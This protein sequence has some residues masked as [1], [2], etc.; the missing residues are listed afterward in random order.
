MTISPSALIDSFAATAG[1]LSDIGILIEL[2]QGRVV[3]VNPCFTASLGHEGAAVL[4]RT[5][6]EARWVKDG[7]AFAAFV[8]KVAAGGS[9]NASIQQMLHRDGHVVE[10]SL[11]GGVLHAD[12]QRF[13]QLVARDVT[14]IEQLRLEREAIFNGVPVGLALTRARHFVHAN[15]SFE[16]LFGFDPGTLAGQSGRVVWPSDEVYQEFGRRVGPDLARGLTVEV[17]VRGRARGAGARPHI[18]L[19]AKVL[20]PL[21]PEVGGTV[22]ICEDVSERVRLTEAIQGA[23]AK[24]EDASRAKSAF[25]ANMSH[26]LRTPLNAVL[27]LARLM[28]H[29]PTSDELRREYLDLIADNASGLTR[30]VS[31]ILDLSKIDA[32]KMALEVVAFDLH[33]LVRTLH[34]SYSVLAK[35]RGLQFGVSIDAGVPKVV[36]SDPVR[37]RQILSNFVSNALKFTSNGSVNISVAPAAPGSTRF[38]VKDSG[39]GF[40]D[41]TRARLFQPFSQADNSTTRR[42]GGTGLGLSIC[43]QLATLMGGSVG[44]ESRI[45]QG[46]VFWVDLPLTA[47]Q[48]APQVSGFGEVEESAMA[49]LRVLVVEDNPVNSLICKAMLEQRGMQVVEAAN[50]ALA[51]AAVAAAADEGKDF[52]VILMDVQMPVMDGLE[53][54]ARLRERYPRLKLP[55]IGLS[56]AAMTSDRDAALQAGMNEFT[57]KPIEPRR[58]IAAISRAMSR[59]RL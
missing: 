56:A 46:S 30:I 33:E 10:L 14:G 55:I 42:H 29:G 18:R 24:A 54:T 26:E 2:P 11:R 57:T 1:L 7:E 27:G 6:S 34:A 39:C 44:V 9:G 59:R 22:W 25:L 40:D 51:V 21:R 23:L 35:T 36:Q 28:Q 32:G 13:V 31:D 47:S 15:A 4:G 3:H 49:G 38:S 12:H 48:E 16:R 17:E 53:A 43:Q 37:L 50:G 5:P 41:E 52:D 19:V 58:L 8:A 45:D 20:D